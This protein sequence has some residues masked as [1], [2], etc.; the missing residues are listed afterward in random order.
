M[1]AI[2]VG[3]SKPE[4]TDFASRFL[5]LNIIESLSLSS[6]FCA[7]IFGK[8]NNNESNIMDNRYIYKI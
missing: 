4:T 7:L 5:S 1:K 6:D 3:K 8:I 2:L